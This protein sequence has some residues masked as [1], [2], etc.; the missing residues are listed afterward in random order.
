[1]L[2]TENLDFSNMALIFHMNPMPIVCGSVKTMDSTAHAMSRLECG[3]VTEK[4]KPFIKTPSSERLRINFLE[5]E[6]RVDKTLFCGLLSR[7]NLQI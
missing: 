1:M 3:F 2:G 6:A 5:S 4:F 7:E